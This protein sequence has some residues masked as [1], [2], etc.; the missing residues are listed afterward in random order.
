MLGKVRKLDTES[1]AMSMDFF[2]FS[3]G[4]GVE[5]HHKCS[6]LWQFQLFNVSVFCST[7]FHYSL[8]K[9]HFYFTWLSSHFPFPLSNL[10]LSNRCK[11]RLH[12]IRVFLSGWFVAFYL[13][14]PMENGKLLQYRAVP[15]ACIAEYTEVVHVENRLIVYA[16]CGENIMF[17]M[18]V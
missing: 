11:D 17:H 6:I 1:G 9:K 16:M 12:K 7:H 18:Y 10:L 4:F 3:R 15:F 13:F 2:H 14:A 8:R 5:R